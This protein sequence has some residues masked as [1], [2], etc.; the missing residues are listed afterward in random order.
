[1]KKWGAGKWDGHE[2]EIRRRNFGMR[3]DQL[4]PVIDVRR[5]VHQAVNGFDDRIVHVGRNGI[6]RKTELLGLLA[7]VSMFRNPLI[8]FVRGALGRPRR[9]RPVKACLLL[10]RSSI[11]LR[12]YQLDG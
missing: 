6:S 9:R 8:Y 4:Q 2:Y 7:F 10:V 3:Q 1:M 5:M 12:R 11:P